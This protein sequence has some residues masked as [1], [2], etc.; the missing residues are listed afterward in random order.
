[1]S[2]CDLTL[3]RD[4]HGRGK[5]KFSFVAE[6]GKDK[7]TCKSCKSS[8]DI[9]LFL[10][11]MSNSTELASLTLMHI[12]HHI[13]VSADCIVNRFVK[14]NKTRSIF[15]CGLSHS[16]NLFMILV[17]RMHCNSSRCTFI[18]F[19]ML[20]R[21]YAMFCNLKSANVTKAAGADRNGGA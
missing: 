10:N 15:V 21:N 17:S 2:I 14:Q 4:T 16:Q 7:S 1:M 8:M 18:V 12:N 20:L 19:S 11:T 6:T 13:P 9:R 5:R 3:F